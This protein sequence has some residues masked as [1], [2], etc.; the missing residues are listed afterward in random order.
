MK[1]EFACVIKCMDGRIQNV[2]SAYMRKKLGVPYIDAITVAGPVKVL[3]EF[4]KEKILADLKFRAG[5][6]VNAHKSEVIAVCGHFDCA[7]VYATDEEQIEMV[8]VAVK[9]VSTWFE[10]VKVIGLFVTS[11]LVV[12]EV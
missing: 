8:H 3:A 2:V 5:I 1:T 6:S 11:D 9:N 4:K 12:H 7:M 10:G